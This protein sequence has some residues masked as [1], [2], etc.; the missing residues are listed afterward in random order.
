MDIINMNFHK[1]VLWFNLS[2]ENDNWS[3]Q[4]RISGEIEVRR[5]LN[6][7]YHVKRELPNPES[8]TKILISGRAE[9]I[10]WSWS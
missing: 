1:D 3:H 10:Q 9:V 5:N 6:D 7:E 8:F 2:L 4:K